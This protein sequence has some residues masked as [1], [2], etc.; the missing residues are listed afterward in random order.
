MAIIP[1]EPG[2]FD[3][4]EIVGRPRSKFSSG[5]HMGP[6]GSMPLVSNKTTAIKDV[7]VRE[8]FGSGP[9][10]DNSYRAVLEGSR[11][12]DFA[13]F[14]ITIQSGS[15]RHKSKSAQISLASTSTRLGYR[16]NLLTS[17]SQA[18]E[19]TFRD[20][21]VD[22]IDIAAQSPAAFLANKSLG[23]IAQ[24][25][26][27]AINSPL[28]TPDP[29]DVTKYIKVQHYLA[30]PPVPNNA[31]P[32]TEYTIDVQF[33]KTPYYSGGQPR[34][35]Q[36]GEV[37]VNKINRSSHRNAAG[38]FDA[39][40]SI[41]F[42]AITIQSGS[43]LETKLNNLLN[44]TRDQPVA[45]NYGKELRV[46]RFEPSV[47]FTKDT[48]RKNVVKD[49]LYP[50]Y[51]HLY[52]NLHWSY[53]NYHSINFFTGSG[54]PEDTAI[55]YLNKLKP[56][57]SVEIPVL[58]DGSFNTDE[59]TK[60]SDSD[61]VSPQAG[62]NVEGV[63]TDDKVFVF[64]STQAV[65]QQSS[66]FGRNI[67]LKRT[68]PSNTLA[69]VRMDIIKAKGS[70]I[71]G[72]GSIF[73]RSGTT[74]DQANGIKISII[75]NEG[76]PTTKVYVLDSFGDYSVAG[77][78]V[79]VDISSQTGVNGILSTLRTSILSAGGHNNKV[80]VGPVLNN[81]LELTQATGG[82]S[83]NKTI[84]VSGDN[85]EKIIVSSFAGGAASDQ[86]NRPDGGALEAPDPAVAADGSITVDNSSPT[87]TN[88]TT[89]TMSSTDQTEIVYV[90][91]TG[92]SNTGHKNGLGQVV[93][94]LNGGPNANAIA[95]K[96]QKAILS[97]NGH[98]GK[99]RAEL[100]NNVVTLTQQAKGAAGNGS[101]VIAGDTDSL[102]TPS[103]FTN[104]FTGEDVVILHK[105]KSDASF[106][107]IYRI[108][109]ATLKTPNQNEWKKVE[110]DISGDLIDEDYEVKIAQSAPS[111]DNHD[112]LI[113]H[114]AKITLETLPEDS[115]VKLPYAYSPREDFTMSFWIKPKIV[116]RDKNGGY[117][118]GT[119]LHLSSSYAI[120]VLSGS[121]VDGF[122]RSDKFRLMFQFD[123]SANIAPSKVP[124]KK[125][126]RSDSEHDPALWSVGSNFKN[127]EYPRD[128]RVIT[129]SLVWKDD[130]DLIFLS[131]DNALSGDTWHHVA[132]RWSAH[133]NNRS[134]SIYI[135]GELD[136]T[137]H[138]NSGSAMPRSMP[139]SRGDP[140]V[141]FVGNYFD[142]R[143]DGDEGMLMSQFFNGNASYQEGLP[144]AF[145]AVEN[146]IPN[147]Q[148]DN[149]LY[150]DPSDSLY[151][152]DHPLKAEIHEVK[153][154]NKFKNQ[155][156]IKSGMS[157]QIDFPDQGLIFYLPVFFTPE[158]PTRDIMQT[159]F[160]TFRST[161]NDPF[162]VALSFGVG[163]KT[164][165]L[166]NFLR[167]HVQKNYPRLLNLTASAITTT[168]TK[169]RTADEW[170][171][172]V[173]AHR[174]GNYTILPCDNGLFRPT[175][176][177]I[178][179]GSQTTKV[180]TGSIN[181]VY[182]D[183]NNY[184]RNGLISLRS[185]VSTASLP[186]NP[187]HLLQDL[188]A[189][190]GGKITSGM[191][192]Q[193]VVDA[194][195]EREK[196]I[197]NQLEGATPE[198]PGVAPGSILSILNRTRDPDSNEVVFFD[199]SNMFYGNRLNP[200]TISIKDIG[201]SGTHGSV[202]ITLK[203]DG[204]GNIY[205]HD[206]VSPPAKWSNVGDVVYDE[207][208]IAIKNPVLSHF[209]RKQF[210]IEFRGEQKVPVL[211]VTVPCEKNTINS[212]SNPNYLPLKPSGDANEYA[213][214]FVYVTG[215]NLHDE[216]FNIV[217]KAT[218]AQPLVKR[219]S[220]TFLV[221]LKMDF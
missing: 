1:L 173:P 74:P 201:M 177:S 84:S 212:S 13:Q 158:T 132:V 153:L 41:Q 70:S 89:I 5:S 118:A 163:G 133:K 27:T 218:F 134:G 214:D 11:L 179:T 155:L 203:D 176:S 32:P 149:F 181:Y 200:N 197:F 154:Y 54:I 63:T 148:I 50:S 37:M 56:K 99:I 97:G 160:Q 108:D 92:Q 26:Q 6:T 143:N 59:F 178:I 159:P 36:T 120:S 60:N 49:V 100:S 66:G 98:N 137:F 199:I 130:A 55:L 109:I 102:L 216:N 112:H 14:T 190:P 75:D 138:I 44:E 191:S 110:F 142:G 10:V 46:V 43:N 35:F 150:R 91:D 95:S 182:R 38:V 103:N 147:Y 127:G 185:M 88:G 210:D 131:S 189:V 115:T 151:E 93:I 45:A 135:D 64:N 129:N 128:G 124:L 90:I 125:Y 184:L 172:S 52:P 12:N 76:S 170:L 86:V 166:P 209:G 136:S 174:K 65:G 106:K 79:K 33:I 171:G 47:K 213:E 121:S 113:V 117:K 192:E 73:L 206:C 72:V 17:A 144:L 165:N 167:E 3:S 16:F 87:I 180:R 221:K 62:F 53:T 205:R 51:R 152:L 42:S 105:K 188:N 30:S 141:L 123:T 7:E 22:I 39:N 25:I 107:E 57:F 162:N 220:D 80:L 19:T 193:E 140:S 122:G 71:P 82:T 23:L 18:K 187:G 28:N 81:T 196:F 146:A 104:G 21:D 161:T 101:I 96:I 69:T 15:Y 58:K 207:G 4:F 126:A 77:N 186:M 183:D 116:G 198:D 139:D 215:V 94:G 83:G 114:D 217:G 195:N 34:Q 111:S 145:K 40:D 219:K 119:V 29:A 85:L 211:E 61:F 175:Y 8:E 164:M 169:S 2:N 24:R 67:S 168:D 202:S 31:N 78:E 68:I 208:I 48:M 194:L 9:V 156:E 157:K 204:Y 20:T